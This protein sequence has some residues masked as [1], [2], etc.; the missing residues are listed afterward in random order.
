ME[1]HLARRNFFAANR[2]TIADIALYAYTHLAHTCD[3]DLARFPAVREWLARVEAQP[4]HVAMDWQ[5]AELA[6]AQ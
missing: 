6:P 5:A 2:Y 1:K 4:H 3:F